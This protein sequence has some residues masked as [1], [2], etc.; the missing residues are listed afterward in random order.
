MILSL[1]LIAIVTVELTYFIN[2]RSA[3]TMLEHTVCKGRSVCLSV[4]HNRDP[5]LNGLR[6]RNTSGEIE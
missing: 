3:L 5:G 6:C 2:V 4:C 1:P